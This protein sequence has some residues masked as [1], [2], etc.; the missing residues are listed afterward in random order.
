MG[1]I[2]E[3]REV[4]QQRKL[5]A[6]GKMVWTGYWFNTLF[7]RHISIYFTWLFIKMG[8]SANAVTFL[9]IPVGLIGAVLCIPH[10]LW[11]NI[12]G[13][14]LLAFAVILDCCDGEI[15]RWTK[16]SSIKGYYLDFVY[17]VLCH[18]TLYILCSLHLY[19]FNGE[20]KYLILAFIS[21]AM[22]QCILNLLYVDMIIKAQSQEKEISNLTQKT[23]TR[24]RTVWRIIKL[25]VLLPSDK[26]TVES[27]SVIAIVVGYFGV[28]WPIMFIAWFLPIFVTFAFIAKI[29][30]KYFLKLPNAEHTKACT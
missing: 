19:V 15:A 11:L 27:A 2:Q 12:V 9:M 6:K 17:H 10:V 5:N 29:T 13:I 8:F 26:T 25:I 23:R 14:F 20:V 1:V 22:S 28:T 3:M 21:Y 18:S 7:T 16:K 4:C 24:K 30:N